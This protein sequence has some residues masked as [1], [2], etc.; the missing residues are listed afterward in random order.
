MPEFPPPAPSLRD[1]IEPFIVFR[2]AGG[3]AECATWQIDSGAKAL[4]LFLSQESATAYCAHAGLG[5]EWRVF[6]PNRA[7]T[8]E[9]L[10]TS[11][12]SG[13]AFAVLDPDLQKARRVF[14][15]NEIL[16][17]IGDLP[18]GQRV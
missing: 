8:L 2:L 12:A 4:A 15:I 10:R 11:R 17:A 5:S 14:D 3:E 18:N 16:T 9:L 6:R 1:E 13:I 7:A